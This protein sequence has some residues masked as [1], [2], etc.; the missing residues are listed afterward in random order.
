MQRLTDRGQVSSL[1]LSY[2]VL[3][4]SIYTSQLCKNTRQ[5]MH[6]AQC[7]ECATCFLLIPTQHVACILQSPAE[8]GYCSLTEIN[9]LQIK[10]PMMNPQAEDSMMWHCT[11]IST[12][13]PAFCGTRF[14]SSFTISSGL[15]DGTKL[16]VPAET[17]FVAALVIYTAPH[18]SHDLM[19]L[20]LSYKLSNAIMIHTKQQHWSKSNHVTLML[21]LSRPIR[22]WASSSSK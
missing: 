22:C 3:P 11:C 1:A 10:E 18:K 15:R 4:W 19:L 21:M 5:T 7:S 12:V 16:C 14:M 6:Q 9:S 13:S 2:N 17:L 8:E 20:L